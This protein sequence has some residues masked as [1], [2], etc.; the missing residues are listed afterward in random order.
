VN[1]VRWMNGR[2]PLLWIRRARTRRFGR[3][4]LYHRVV[5]DGMDPGLR[6]LLA[7]AVTRSTFRRQLDYLA[8]HHEVVGLHEL[9]DRVDDPSGAVA[10]TFDDGYADNLHHALPLLRERGMPATIFVV[11]G[12]VE[13]GRHPAWDRLARRVAANGPRELRLDAE[14]ESRRFA[15]T[16]SLREQMAAAASWLETLSEARREAALGEESRVDEDRPLDVA[17]LRLA[18]RGG[19]RVGAHSVRHRRL[20]TLTPA[21][22]DEEL[23]EC[24]ASLEEWLGHPVEHVAYPY[25]GPHDYDASTMEAAR[26]A[27]FRAA[28]AAHEGLV[29]AET[30]RFAIPR[31]GTRESEDRFRIRL[32]HRPEPRHAG[33]S[34]AASGAGRRGRD[35][36]ALAGRERLAP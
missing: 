27:G 24:K 4:L 25:G 14:D 36:A 21:E 35:E 1:V 12:Y 29:H 19:A 23:S 11:S 10:V 8:R 26:R 9:L 3:V 18:E 20:A 16:G 13:T 22:V 15:F 7:G 2:G 6:G 32:A 5:D 34:D 31:I 33:P 17:E 28:F 30:D